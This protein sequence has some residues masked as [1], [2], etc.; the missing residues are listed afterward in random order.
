MRSTK[1][2][3]SLLELSVVLV[4]IAV[5]LG[6]AITLTAVSVENLAANTTNAKL[7]ALQQALYDYR[8]AYN[9]LPCPANSSYLLT[10]NYYGVE[11]ARVGGWCSGGVPEADTVEAPG[12]EIGMVPVRTLG[13]PDDA[14]IDGWGRRIGYAVSK[15]YVASNAFSSVVATDATTRLTILN[16]ASDAV[17]AT[18]GAYVLVS[19]GKNGHGAYSGATAAL[20]NAAVTNSNELL[21][22]KCDSTGAYDGGSATPSY[23]VQGDEQPDSTNELNNFDDM[24]VF[25]RRADLRNPAK[26]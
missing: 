7:K 15:D 4:I 22:C 16:N 23:F 3:F 6:G 13:L 14:A 26:E 2:G 9:R 11:A 20:I 21:N 19:H 12:A 18:T 24:V 5:L 1:S 8:I 25:A 17:L 10:D